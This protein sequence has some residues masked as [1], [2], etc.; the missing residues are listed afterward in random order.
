MGT[1]VAGALVGE[2]RWVESMIVDDWWEIG[3][4]KDR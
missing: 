3:G 4:D 1:E 2:V